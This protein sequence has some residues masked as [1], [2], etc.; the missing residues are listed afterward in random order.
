MAL[1]ARE[2]T[3]RSGRHESLLGTPTE[4]PRRRRGA[5]AA[6]SEGSSRVGLNPTSDDSDVAEMS[7]GFSQTEP[8]VR[9]TWTSPKL[10]TGCSQTPRYAQTHLENSLVR[11]PGAEASVHL[12]EH[13]R[14]VAIVAAA[15]AACGRAT[16]S[17]E[18]PRRGRGVS[19]EYPCLSGGVVATRRH[20]ISTSQPRRRRDRLHE[21]STSRPRRRHDPC[22]KYQRGEI[23]V[24]HLRRAG[25]RHV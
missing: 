9:T 10:S 11:P 1:P 20:G 21:T 25:A 15:V 5:A 3:A 22:S 4:F 17:T 16:V 14:V 24:A 2:P 8:D 6:L 7:T 23:T 18:R 19:T 13:A 12:V